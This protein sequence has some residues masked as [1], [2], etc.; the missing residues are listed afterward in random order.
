MKF[1]LNIY[2]NVSFSS[3]IK[4]LPCVFSCSAYESVGGITRSKQAVLERAIRASVRNY[5]R[6]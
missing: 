3:E 4:F 5:S 6:N 1:L 2:R